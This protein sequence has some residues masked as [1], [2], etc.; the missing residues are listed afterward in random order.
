LFS[1]YLIDGSGEGVGVLGSEA[2]GDTAGSS[3]ETIM[4]FGVLDGIIVPPTGL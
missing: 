1:L 4:F 3:G 2:G